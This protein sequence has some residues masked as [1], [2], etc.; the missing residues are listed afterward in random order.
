MNQLAEMLDFLN[1]AERLD[2][3]FGWL[4]C[5]PLQRLYIQRTPG[6]A[7]FWYEML[8]R[9]RGIHIWGRGCARGCIY[10]SVR[11]KHV[12][13]VRLLIKQAGG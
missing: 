6:R 13:L 7:G 5:G 1:L 2:E 4:T 3:L 11:R 9:Q 12:D 10:F 8:L